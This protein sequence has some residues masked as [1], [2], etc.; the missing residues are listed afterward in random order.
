MNALTSFITLMLAISIASERMAEV[1]SQ[2]YALHT[3][4]ALLCILAALPQ[5]QASDAE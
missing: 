3:S 1:F 2:P 4:E 5:I